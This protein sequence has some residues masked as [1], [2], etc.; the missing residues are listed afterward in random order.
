MDS[1]SLIPHVPSKHLSYYPIQRTS[2]FFSGTNLF[3]S[4]IF[5]GP[6]IKCVTLL[7]KL[8]GLHILM[9]CFWFPILLIN[10]IKSDNNIFATVWMLYCLEISSVR[11][12]S[13]SSSNSVSHN[14][15]E[16]RQIAAKF[17]AECHMNVSCPI[18]NGVHVSTWNLMNTFFAVLI[19][20]SILTFWT[21]TRIAN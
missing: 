2:H 9:I 20:I 10:L 18:P 19:S 4:H 17:S 15:S 11:L 16:H 5:L 3:S 14:V 21:L 13:P 6:N 7:G 12:I 1:I 8:Q